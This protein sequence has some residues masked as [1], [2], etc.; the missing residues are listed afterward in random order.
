MTTDPHLRPHG[1]WDRQLSDIQTLSIIE[2]AC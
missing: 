2:V 1:H